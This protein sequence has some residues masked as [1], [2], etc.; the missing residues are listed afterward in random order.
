MLRGLLA[1]ALI[2]GLARPGF[3]AEPDSTANPAPRRPR[4]AATTPT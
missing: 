2:A 3:A 1:V 4:P